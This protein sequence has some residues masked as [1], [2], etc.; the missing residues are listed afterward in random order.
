MSKI[1]NQVRIIAGKWRGRKINFPDLLKLRPTPDR[2]RETLFNWLTPIIVDACCLDLFAGSGALGFEALSRGAKSVLM[3]DNDP[4][5][6][7]A[8]KKSRTKLQAEEASIFQAHI[9]QQALKDTGPYEIVFLDPPFHKDLLTPCCQW[10]EESHYLAQHAYIYIECEASLKQVA[11]P[12]NWTLSRQKVAG[13][14]AY[15][16][17]IR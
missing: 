9:P 8:L 2:V 6:I 10:L 5:V 12:E 4:D 15:Y 7:D 3:V 14:V 11:V 16:L 1:S 17:Y 13:Q